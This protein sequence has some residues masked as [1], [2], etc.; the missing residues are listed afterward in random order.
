MNGRY[1]QHCFSK[2]SLQARKEGF[3]MLKVLLNN[4]WHSQ[5]NLIE[6][7]Q[8]QVP[9]HHGN[10]NTSFKMH[11]PGGVAEFIQHPMISTTMTCLKVTIPMPS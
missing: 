11:T 10:N 2:I 3:G 7:S 8:F 9:G 1:P 5:H 4:F 6:D